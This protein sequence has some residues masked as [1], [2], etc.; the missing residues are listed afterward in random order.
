MTSGLGR[1]MTGLMGGLLV[2]RIAKWRDGLLMYGW[3][4]R[5]ENTKSISAVKLRGHIC[6]I[7]EQVHIRTPKVEKFKTERKLKFELFIT[8]SNTKM[9]QPEK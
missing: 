5:S 4:I 7:C 1:L 2:G 3:L 9:L 6:N 8:L